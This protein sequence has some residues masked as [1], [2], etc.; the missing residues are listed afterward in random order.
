[1]SQNIQISGQYLTFDEIYASAN[2]YFY[3]RFR[4]FL[5][6]KRALVLL[7]ALRQIFEICRL[8]L[9]LLSR[10]ISSSSTVFDDWMVFPSNILFNVFVLWKKY[11]LKLWL[12]SYHFIIFKPLY[13]SISSL[14]EM[15]SNSFPQTYRVCK[16]TDI[17]FFNG[18]KQVI[19]KNIEKDSP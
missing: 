16:V 1:M 15:V 7:F 11:K 18:K 9:I 14:K 13:C 17:C 5:I 2:T 12:I 10:M 8:K 19:D 6:R 3:S 4:N